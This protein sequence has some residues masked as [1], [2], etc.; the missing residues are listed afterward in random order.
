M[1]YSPRLIEA[2]SAFTEVMVMIER[3]GPPARGRQRQHAAGNLLGQEKRATQV[4]GQA[5]VVAFDRNVEQIASVQDPDAGIVDQAVDATEGLERGVDQLRLGREISDIGGEEG[6]VPA[7]LGDAREA[8]LGVLIALE[9]GD[10]DIEAG[11]GQSESD[12]APD[13]AAPAGHERDRS[14][15]SLRHRSL[16][17]RV[18]NAGS[19]CDLTPSCMA[20]PAGRSSCAPRRAGCPRS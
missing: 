3:G 7:P 1:Q 4:D 19:M 10:D 16:R 17:R 14:F 6:A 5:T 9:V 18:A 20:A 11:L 2:I 15:Q 13:A 12:A 8:R